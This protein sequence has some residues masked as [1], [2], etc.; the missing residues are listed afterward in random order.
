MAGSS[1]QPPNRPEDVLPAY[2]FSGAD[3]FPARKFVRE[4]REALKN[5]QGE[6]AQV[7]TFN[8][9]DR[10][11]GDVLDAARTLPFMFS[12]WRILAVEGKGA[13]QENLSS[14]EAASFGDYFASP[15]PR[16]TIVVMFQGTVH[17]TKPL[18]KAFFA[19]PA[20]VVRI[21][22]LYPLKDKDLRPLI[23]ERFSAL[24]KRATGDAVN[25]ILD[26]TESDIARIDSEVEKLALYLGPRTTVEEEDV[27]AL[28]SARSFQNWELNA[29]LE[30]GEIEKALVILN[31]Q[32][33]KGDAPELLLGVL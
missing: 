11:F 1:F 17:K 2:L 12:P 32:F 24:G 33:D 7:E 27:A 31:S 14:G 9:A 4:L 25:R 18:G 30:A 29:A 28:S 15:S 13:G 16:T 23:E 10:R 20:S 8:L 19:L 22:D 26:I 5:D 3:M 21:V 6:P